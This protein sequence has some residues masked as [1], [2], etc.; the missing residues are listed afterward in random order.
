[1]VTITTSKQK[2]IHVGSSDKSAVRYLMKASGK[3]RQEV[4][5]AIAKVGGNL[6]TLQRE[7]GCKK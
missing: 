3:S 5:A 7:L 2:R 4:S 1:M 6:E